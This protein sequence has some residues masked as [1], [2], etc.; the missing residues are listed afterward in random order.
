MS[1]PKGLA[2]A[3]A[4]ACLLALG[5]ASPAA[6]QNIANPLGTT[7]SGFGSPF[8][9]SFGG[10]AVVVGCTSV[11]LVGTPSPPAGVVPNAIGGPSTRM[12]KATPFFANCTANIGGTMYAAGV[13]AN[14]D[15][16]YAIDA[17]NPATGA[18][19]QRLQIGF[20][21]PNVLNAVT[22]DVPAAGCTIGL[23]QQPLIHNGASISITGQ[24]TPWPPPANG[25]T[26]AHDVV[27]A[28]ARTAAGC[29]GVVNPN[30]PASMK[31]DVQITGAWAGP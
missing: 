13:T 28:I 8:A 2:A 23:H 11:T 9:F 21:C 18:S 20:S 3:L 10:G 29:A 5:A 4:A 24:D 25:M 15:W 19:A 12:A 26:I 22:I 16:G 6:A 17:F 7:F 31:G 30:P 14:C 27:G 1:S